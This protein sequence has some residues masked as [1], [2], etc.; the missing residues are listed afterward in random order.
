M[1][2]SPLSTFVR[3]IDEPMAAGA[4]VTADG[5]ALVGAIQANGLYGVRPST[6]AA[7]ERFVGFVH[8]QTSMAPFLQPNA[9]KTETLTLNAGGTAVLGQAPLAGTVG[10]YNVTAGAAVAA[11]DIAIAADG[12]TITITGGA[13]ATVAVTYSYA[14]TI[15]QF[16]ALFG[17]VQ[18]GGFAG[19]QIG[20]IGV[21]KQGVIYTDQF[22]T[23]VNWRAATA[24]KLAANGKVTDQSGTG[25][26]I[27]AVVRVVPSDSYPFLGLDFIAPN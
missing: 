15:V 1:I 6:G 8:A 14:L 26:A 20:Q 23:A 27:D 12:V 21:A 13:G 17:D 19:A 11:G 3:S 9:T 2:Y 22:D 25:V 24:V 10:A 18:P 7:G 5:Q 16:R 4:V